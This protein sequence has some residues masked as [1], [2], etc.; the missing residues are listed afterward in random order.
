MGNINSCFQRDKNDYIKYEGR[1]VYCETCLARI[2]FD[3]IYIMA[4]TSR[5]HIFV[6][7][8]VM[9][10]GWLMIRPLVYLEFHLDI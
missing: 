2:S 7:K 10:F 8:L 4:H 6:L 9:G 5:T 1:H 3:K